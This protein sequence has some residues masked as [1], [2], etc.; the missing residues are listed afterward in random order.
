[1]KFNTDSSFVG[2][3][4]LKQAQAEQLAEF[5]AWAA[6]NLWENFHTSHFDWWMFPI[7]RSSAY[8][9]AWTVYEGEIDALKRD[10]RYLASYLRGVE[11][12][13]ASW[14]WDVARAAPIP[15]LKAGQS[16]HFWPVR[17]FKAALSVQLFGYAPLFD[18]LKTY[19]LGLAQR[20]E[21]MEYNGHDLGW[22][23]TGGVDPRI[24]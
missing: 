12:V 8:G 3:E 10:G 19:A 14:G 17:L 5:E 7:N 11:L 18:S 4:K 2:L 15:D 22:L 6:R 1:M 24:T 20:G 21:R 23:F 16:W 9:L 13:S